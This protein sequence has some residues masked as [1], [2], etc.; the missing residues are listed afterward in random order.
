MKATVVGTGV[1][2]AMVVLAGCGG[3]GGSAAESSAPAIRGDVASSD[4]SDPE[5]SGVTSPI[6]P[7]VIDRILN[8]FAR[9]VDRVV[10]NDPGITFVAEGPVYVIVRD[11]KSFKTVVKSP[12]DA[13]VVILE[14]GVPDVVLTPDVTEKPTADN[15]AVVTNKRFEV[16]VDNVG[17]YRYWGPFGPGNDALV[18]VSEAYDTLAEAEKACAAQL[19]VACFTVVLLD[20]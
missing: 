6:D 7:E 1:A 16:Y 4:A 2:A 19:D 18:T 17:K 10:K 12:A 15:F 13:S 5:Y 20:N 9:S 3:S 11:E 14:Q 8:V